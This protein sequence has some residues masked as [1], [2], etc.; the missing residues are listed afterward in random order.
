MVGQSRSKPQSSAGRVEGGRQQH[1]RVNLANHVFELI[2]RTSK[3]GFSEDVS[4]R[5]DEHTRFGTLGVHDTSLVIAC[6]STPRRR[7]CGWARWIVL[8]EAIEFQLCGFGIGALPIKLQ[9]RSER[10]INGQWRASC[11]LTALTRA[12]AT[13][14]L[15][16]SLLPPRC[17]RH[18]C[19]LHLGQVALSVVGW[20]LAQVAQARVGI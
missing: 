15:L 11:A 13:M 10:R 6:P 1:R 16:H 12:R 2:M 4:K 14:C 9:S 18:H 8:Q 17:S 3:K 19:F 7:S 5:K 20:P